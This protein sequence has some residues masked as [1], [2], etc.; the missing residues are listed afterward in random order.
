MQRRDESKPVIKKKEDYRRTIN[1]ILGMPSVFSKLSPL[2]PPLFS[3]QQQQA[4]F[5]FFFHFQQAMGYHLTML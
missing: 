4:K 2:T 5:N 1:F 3:F